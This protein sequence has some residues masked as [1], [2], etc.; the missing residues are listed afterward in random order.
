VSRGVHYYDNHNH[1]HKVICTT[2]KEVKLDP[3]TTCT[4]PDC[5]IILEVS[6][7]ATHTQ[8]FFQMGNL[9]PNNL[10][11]KGSGG[12]PPEMK[13]IKAAVLDSREFDVIIHVEGNQT[14]GPPSWNEALYNQAGSIGVSQGKYTFQFDIVY[15]SILANDLL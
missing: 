6:A 9:V 8:V 13:F 14:F 1:D 3:D 11:G 15:C 2:T 5:G 10:G 12:G 7:N 4:G